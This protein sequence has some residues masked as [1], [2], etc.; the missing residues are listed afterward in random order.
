MM[1]SGGLH[2]QPDGFREFSL[3]SVEREECFCAAFQRDC[4]VEKVNRALSFRGCVL[5]AEFVGAAKCVHPIHRAMDEKSFA[6]I[7]IKAIHGG[8]EFSIGNVPACLCISQ[9]ITCFDTMEGREQQRLGKRRHVFHSIR[10][11]RVFRYKRYE[12]TR[13]RVSGRFH[14]RRSVPKIGPQLFCSFL[15]HPSPNGRKRL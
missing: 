8:P 9:S 7:I 12:K 6:Q 4:Y 10:T 14:L 13:I 2:F 11:P 3:P 1:V 5:G 15:G